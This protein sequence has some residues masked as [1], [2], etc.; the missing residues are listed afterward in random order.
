M[1]HYTH[2]CVH[3]TH[4]TQH[5]AHYTLH[6]THYTTLSTQHT[7]HYTL[8]TTHKTLHTTH[9]CVHTTH[10]TQLYLQQSFNSTTLHYKKPQ[11]HTWLTFPHYI[12]YWCH[13]VYFMWP[14]KGEWKF[15]Q[16]PFVSP[17]KLGKWHNFLHFS[18]LLHCIRK[19][20][21]QYPKWVWN[22]GTH[23]VFW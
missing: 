9:K 14:T 1:L 12:S 13:R 10:Y 8:H 18:L 15:R 11:H 6:T 23:P 2:N 7:T 5:T 22:T 16:P 17:K 4:N 19:F 21:H 20:I 3:T